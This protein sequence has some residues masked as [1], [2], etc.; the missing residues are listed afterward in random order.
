M[1]QHTWERKVLPKLQITR[2]STLIC[3]CYLMFWDAKS[4]AV[5]LQPGQDLRENQQLLQEAGD[6]SYKVPA[7]L[8]FNSWRGS[9]LHCPGAFMF[10]GKLGSWGSAD[11]HWLGRP[12]HVPVILLVLA[13]CKIGEYGGNSLVW[14]ATEQKNSLHSSYGDGETE[15]ERERRYE[16]VEERNAIFK[17]WLEGEVSPAKRGLGMSSVKYLSTLQGET[18]WLPIHRRRALMPGW[19]MGSSGCWGH[20]FSCSGVHGRI[21]RCWKFWKRGYR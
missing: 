6:L 9:G 12:R 18:G 8:D 7:M 3:L 10:G 13:Y 1:N 2:R 20:G 17:A 19:Q 16:R 15:R 14:L 11:S 4:H 5:Y 21:H